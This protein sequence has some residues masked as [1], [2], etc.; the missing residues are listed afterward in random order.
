MIDVTMGKQDLLDGDT[1]LRRAGDDVVE[2]AA[3]VDDGGALGFL[4]P[5]QRA[6][7]GEG[8]DGKNAVVHGSRFYRPR[9]HA[10]RSGASSGAAIA[11]RKSD[12]RRSLSAF[13]VPFSTSQFEA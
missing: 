11:A 9:V 2:V 10:G 4:A 1:Q 12:S 5:E 8:R 3:G 13:K 7:L 6:V